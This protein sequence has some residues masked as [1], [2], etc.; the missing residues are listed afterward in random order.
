MTDN[1]WDPCV[2][3]GPIEDGFSWCRKPHTVKCVH[4]ERTSDDH[5]DGSCPTCGSQCPG[6]TPVGLLYVVTGATGEYADKSE[7]PVVAYTDEQ[8]AQAKAVRCAQRAKSYE[9]TRKGDPFAGNDPPAA[10]KDEDPY[11]RVDY[12]GTSYSVVK[13]PV[14]KRGE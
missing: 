10:Y 13:V 2:E 14:G 7:W 5:G 4:C 1:K 8:D 12:T 11:L 6:W 9:L 3:H